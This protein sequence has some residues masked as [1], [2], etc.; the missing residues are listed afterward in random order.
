MKKVFW[1]SVFWILVVA[2]FRWYLRWFDDW[3][4]NSVSNLIWVEKICD[5]VSSDETNQDLINQI[6]SMQEQLNIISSSLSSED[7]KDNLLATNNPQNIKLYYFNQVEDSKLPVNQQLNSS[8]VLPVDRVIPRSNNLIQ[9]TINMLIEWNL[10]QEEVSK[11][12][13]TEFPNNAFRL[14]DTNLNSDWTLELT[15]SEVP[16]FTSWW[17]ARVFILRV[18][19]EKTAKQFP[20][21]KIVKILP[22]TLF[23]P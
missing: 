8:S 2:L 10:S 3:L 19:I 6:K 7:N 18:S 4:A 11:W 12:F 23:Q 15:F 20:N 1:T 14:I 17:S 9:D 5:D 22:E 21:V 16:G 13:T